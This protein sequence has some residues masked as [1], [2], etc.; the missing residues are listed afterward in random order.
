MA[1]KE[2]LKSKLEELEKEYSKTSYNK[3][4]N[5]HLGLLRAK[6]ANIKKKMSERK[7]KKGKGFTVKKTGD[8]T[9]ALVGFPNA[10]KSSLLKLLT[11]VESKVADYAFTTLD[12]IPGML[13][14]K[15]AGIQVFDLPGLIEGAHIGRG[16]GAQI[17]SAIRTADMVLFVIDAANPHNLYTL[18][19]ELGDLGIHA[20]RERPGIR[21]EKLNSGGV[22]I[23]NKGYKIPDKNIVAK[24]LNE[25]GIYN[26]IVHF[27]TD[28]SEEEVI[29]ALAGNDIYLRAIVA[30]NKIDVN[31]NYQKVKAE[32]EAKTKMR[33][34]PISAL[35]NRNIDELKE[36]IFKALRFCRVYLKP[37]DGPADY[38]KPIIMSEGSSVLDTAKKL[39]T[40]IAKSLKY[41]YVTGKSAK[42]GNQ[43]VGK[44][45]ILSDED[46][47]TLV[48]QKD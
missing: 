24:I 12:A 39:H 22:K 6:I 41:A 32:M 8:A 13:E 5:K 18:I 27:D 45:H 46:V 35:K 23:E 16:G 10:G 47:L 2:V 36:G 40:D 7:K 20:G 29:D 9:I 34:I 43:K 1:D 15:G 31:E 30:L 3:A 48:Y 44:D 25:F 26:G 33:V 42:F 21:V 38:K 11:N 14:Y 37:K 4:T 28:S 17:S 19:K